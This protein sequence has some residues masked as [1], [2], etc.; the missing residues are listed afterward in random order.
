MID[1]EKVL[2]ALPKIQHLFYEITVKNYRKIWFAERE[3]YMIKENKLWYKSPA[4]SWNEALPLGNGRLGAMIF[5]RTAH[6]R[7]QCNEDTVWSGGFRDRNNPDAK[8]KLAEIRALLRQGRI[9][10]AENLSRYSLTG[11]PEFQRTYQ[12]LADLELNFHDMPE[13]AEEYER[14][15]YLDTATAVTSF[16]VNGF[17]YSREA[18]IS[19]P[20]NTMIV[21][22]TTDNPAGFSFD[23]RI[24]RNRLCDGSGHIDENT[25]FLDG[26]SGDENGITFCAMLSGSH[27]GGS[28]EAIG[29]YLYFHNA[30]EVCLF[31]TAATTF[32]TE[33]PKEACLQTLQKTASISYDALLAEHS[34]DYSTYEST[35]S[36]ALESSEDR[37]ALPTDERL[38]KFT[39]DFCDPGLLAL[40]FRFGRYLLISCSR[41]GSLPANLQG[42]WCQDF[43][44]PWDSKYTININ[45]EMNYWLAENCALADLHLPLFEHLKRM[46]PH[47]KKTAEVMYGARGFVAHHNTD[48]WGDTAP[49][50]TYVPASYW[51]MGAAWLCLHVWEHYQYS[52]DKTFLEENYYLLKEACVFFADYLIENEH[53]EFIVSPSVSPEN[54]YILPNGESGRLCEGCAMDSQILFELVSAN[55]AAAEIMQDSEDWKQ[56]LQTMLAKL[57]PARIGKHGN[58][59]EWTDDYDE[60]ELGHRHIS[61]LFA[62]FPGNSISPDATP[63]LAAAARKTLERRLENGG[64][65]TGWSRAWITNFWARLKDSKK[66]EENI[67]LLLAKSTLPNLF[68]NHPPFQIDG[69]FGG[70]AAMAN[71][72]MQSFD[73]HILLLPALPAAWQAGEIH[74]LRAKGGLTLDIIWQNGKLT[75]AVLH[76]AVPYKGTVQYG[77]EQ[78]TVELKAEQTLELNDCLAVLV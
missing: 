4:P 55:L 40:Y 33:N 61:H 56:T 52:M 15:L 36:F 35:L 42:I 27:S 8:A 32:R 44:S 53:G 26:T 70:T 47:G 22:L 43:L 69:N 74:G 66:A 5:G 20:Q 23:V 65:H 58:I 3:F 72:L 48:I 63:E 75:S 24:V 41:P 1:E 67:N 2:L 16:T 73:G 62:L 46:Y 29:E 64:G 71:M 49:Q 76:A 14:A 9:A 38:A 17:H 28:M 7:I 51:V 13:E 68:D 10:D 6:E 37:A 39:Q 11:T 77:D 18:F 54:T 78:I 59:I 50:D 60:A 25:I 45:T 57:P 34:K 19:A 31:F 21:R 12:T 30:Q